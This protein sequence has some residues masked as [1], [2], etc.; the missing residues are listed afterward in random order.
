MAH[1]STYDHYY[2]YSHQPPP[3]PSMPQELNDRNGI[4]T[5]FVSG[6]P[7][8]VKAR[9]IHNLFRRRSGFDYC[10]LKYTGR[11]NQ[12]L[13]FFLNFFSYSE[14]FVILFDSLERHCKRNELRLKLYPIIDTSIYLWQVV[15]FATFLNHQS[16][17]SALHALNVRILLSLLLLLFNG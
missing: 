11:G 15:A 9:E 6:L 14:V 2:I 16:A 4:N 7:D 17:V 10:Q 12:V 8:D 13:F 1:P 3:P 5:L